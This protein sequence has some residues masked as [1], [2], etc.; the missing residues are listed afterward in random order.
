MKVVLKEGL[1]ISSLPGIFKEDFEKLDRLEG[2]YRVTSYLIEI[3]DLEELSPRKGP[4]CGFC[5]AKEETKKRTQIVEEYK[6]ITTF[7]KVLSD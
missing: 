3:F 1:D 4:P 5:D 6:P 2:Q 7:S